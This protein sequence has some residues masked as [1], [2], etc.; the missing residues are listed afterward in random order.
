MAREAWP[1][2]PMAVT[3]WASLDGCEMDEVLG[4]L[5]ALTPP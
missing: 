4:T 5:A 3:T 1:G 2:A